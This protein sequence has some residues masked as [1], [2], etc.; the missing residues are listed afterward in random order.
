MENV[1]VVDPYQGDNYTFVF[2]AR[3]DVTC[4]RPMPLYSVPGMIDRF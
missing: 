2:D 3:I 1:V 4:A